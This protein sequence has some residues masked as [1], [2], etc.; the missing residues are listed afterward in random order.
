[1]WQPITV[2]MTAD[3]TVTSVI[4]GSNHKFG[5]FE[6]SSW[7]GQNLVN[8]TGLVLR[9]IT[10]WAMQMSIFPPMPYTGTCKGTA[11]FGYCRLPAI[12]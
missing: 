1:M 12:R 2:N 6:R 4:A 10:G 7:L 9:P 8:C 11:S 5:A 3:T